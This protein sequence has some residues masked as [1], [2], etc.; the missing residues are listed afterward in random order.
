MPVKR[1]YKEFLRGEIQPEPN[2]P[3][4]GRNSLMPTGSDGLVFRLK[5]A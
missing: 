4:A 3:K 1:D 2:H 5:I